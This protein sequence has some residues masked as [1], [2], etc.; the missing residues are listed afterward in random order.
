MAERRTQD[1]AEPSWGGQRLSRARWDDAVAAGDDDERRLFPSILGCTLRPA[2]RHVPRA[3]NVVPI[4]TAHA[5]QRRRKRKRNPVVD[6]ILDRNEAARLRRYWGRSRRTG[7]IC[8]SA[9]NGSIRGRRR[10]WIIST[11]MFVAGSAELGE[12]VPEQP[13]KPRRQLTPGMEIPRRRQQRHAGD[14]RAVGGSARASAS[15]PPMQ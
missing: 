10:V 1:S 11:G 6:P 15:S 4:P 14:L 9:R 2:T 7:R 3:G 5:V 8:A 12:P 13:Q